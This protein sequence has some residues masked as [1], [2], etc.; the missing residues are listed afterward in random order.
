MPAPSRDQLTQRLTGFDRVEHPLDQKLVD[1]GVLALDDQLDLL[2]GFAREVADDERH[3]P[4]DLAHRHEADAHD[5][6]AFDAIDVE[7]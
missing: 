4:E 3:P 5:A 7:E 6:V 1:L 2:A